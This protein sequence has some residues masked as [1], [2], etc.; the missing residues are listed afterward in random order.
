[1]VLIAVEERDF[2][3]LKGVRCAV[4]SLKIILNASNREI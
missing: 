1:M 2:D 3:I 4:V